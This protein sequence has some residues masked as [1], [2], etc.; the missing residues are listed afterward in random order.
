MRSI[1]SDSHHIG[2][3]VLYSTGTMR[4]NVYDTSCIMINDASDSSLSF[5]SNMYDSQ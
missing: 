3:P 2:C 4:S 5:R 1:A